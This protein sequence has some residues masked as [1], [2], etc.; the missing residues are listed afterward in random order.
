M[1]RL[2]LIVLV[3]AVVLLAALPF[4]E[5]RDARP[6]ER[7]EAEPSLAS[8][9]AEDLRTGKLSPEEYE[10]AKREEQP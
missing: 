6:A 8:A 9:L 2:T 5:R 4:L 10:A 1:D 3:C 7:R